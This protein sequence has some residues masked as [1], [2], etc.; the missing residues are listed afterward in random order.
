MRLHISL[1]YLTETFANSGTIEMSLKEGLRVWGWEKED[2]YHLI[3]ICSSQQVSQFLVQ[4]FFVQLSFKFKLAPFTLGVIDNV[5]ISVVEIFTGR[6]EVVAKVLFYRCVSVHRGE[7]VCLSAYWDA[8]P[9]KDQGDTPWGQG[10]TP[11]P[12]PGRPLLD[13]AD[14]PG[15]RQTPPGTRETPPPWDQA[16]TPPP[17]APDQADPPGSRLQHMVYERPV[18][19]LLECILVATIS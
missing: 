16:D 10:D 13:Q 14:P 19:I 8:M 3:S 5:S 18:R 17:P 1:C 2:I 11:S 7:G 12:W 4:F 6:N 9:P 15:T